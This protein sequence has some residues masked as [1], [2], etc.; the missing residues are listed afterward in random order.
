M[1][2]NVSISIKTDNDTKNLIQKAAQNIGLSTNSFMLMV[3]KQA[4][5]SKKIVLDNELED[6]NYYLSEIKKAEK[7]NKTNS[8]KKSWDDLKQNYAI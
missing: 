1:S 8:P 5:K 2:N 7:Y 4:A 6:D 3:A